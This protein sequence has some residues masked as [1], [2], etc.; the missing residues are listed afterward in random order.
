MER[1]IREEVKNRIADRL[2]SEDIRVGL[3]TSWAGYPVIYEDEMSSTN[4]TARRIAESGAGHGTL[5]VAGRQLEGRGRRGRVWHS[6]DESGIWMSLLLRPSIQPEKASMLTLVAAM[7][8]Y[9]A[10]SSRMEGCAIKWPNDIVVHGRKVCGILTE[11]SA[12]MNRVHDVIVGIGVNVNTEVFPEEISEVA[13]SIYTESGRYYSRCEIICDI[14]RGFEKYYEQF[15]RTADLSVIAPEYN[16]RL[17]NRGRRVFIEERNRRFEGTAEGID[18][19]GSL[20]VRRDNGILE[21]IISGE[22]SVRGVLGYV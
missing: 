14:L 19:E 1:W 8:V 10:L 13:A 3:K 9:D 20:L 2:S 5:V 22:V 6:P 4:Q 18:P 16:Q 15:I 21:T 11:M 12:E 17:V 7:A